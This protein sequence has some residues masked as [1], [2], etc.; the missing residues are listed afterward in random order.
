MIV[1]KSIEQ[2][3][4][5]VSEIPNG[6]YLGEWYGYDVSFKVG[7]RLFIITGEACTKSLTADKV[8]VT[9]KDGEVGFVVIDN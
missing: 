6:N 8:L 5:P 2:I 1:K 9:I 3:E 4:T 7:D